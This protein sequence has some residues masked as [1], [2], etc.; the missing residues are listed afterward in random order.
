MTLN[1][2][3]VCFVTN[4]PSPYRVNFFNELN[5]HFDVTVLYEL[6]YSNER[7]NSWKTKNKNSFKE[8]YFKSVR[9]SK[10]SSISFSFYKYLNESYD[11]IVLLNP[12][13]PTGILINFY[14]KLKSVDFS[15]EIDGGL[16]TNNSYFKNKIK[17]FIFGNAKL[18]LSPSNLADTYINSY[19]D[20]KDKIRRY[21]FSS[22]F[23][24]DI[25]VESDDLK[26]K[27]L[28]KN[29]FGVRENFVVLS[30]GRFIKIKNYL[31]LISNWI[32]V[33]KEIAYVLVGEGEDLKNYEAAIK[34]NELSNVYLIPFQ[35]E[36]LNRLYK[37]SDV[38]LHPSCYDPWG[39]VV[40][41]AMA[42]G[43]P[44]LSTTKTLAAVE[45]VEEGLNG[46]I[47]D[48]KDYE[49][50][51][52][53][54]SSLYKNPHKIKEYRSNALKKAISYSIETMV[55]DHIKFFMTIDK[56]VNSL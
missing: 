43:L 15:I 19:V 28:L 17:K 51:L 33:D 53:M 6:R 47:F 32:H 30:V 18:I 23:Q 4:I 8:F 35:T 45:M 36:L 2:K 40:N 25:L 16:I 7:N 21:R 12:F 48:C 38:F 24:K 20:V 39:L 1:K 42:N 13:T 31:S 46:H 41:E 5:K 29:Q 56:R 44:V 11:F 22:V 14:L 26:E 34:L 10:D 49:S 27:S 9:V 52:M 3:K 55:E 37:E 54:I 50:Q